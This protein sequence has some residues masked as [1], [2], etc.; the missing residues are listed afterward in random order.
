M[1]PEMRIYKVGDLPFSVELEEPWTFMH[2]TDAVL[3]RINGCAGGMPVP[4]LPTRAGDQV[5]ART[6]VTKKEE[7]PADY[8]PTTLDFSQ[9]E[10]FH[11]ETIS[12]EDTAFHMT[13]RSSGFESFSNLPTDPSVRLI[14]KITDDL[15][16]FDIY[17]KEK[18]NIFLFKYETEEVF[19]VL[20]IHNSGKAADFY[21]RA[22]TKPYNVMFHLNMALMIQY[23]YSSAGSSALLIHSS[24][25]EHDGMANMFLGESGTGKSTHSR[26]WLEHISGTSL[27]NDDN[28]VLKMVDGTPYVYG[29]PWSG[30]TPCYINKKLPVRTLVSLKQAPYNKASRL[31]GVDAFVSILTSAS[32]IRWDDRIDE[33]ITDTASSIAD[34]T[35][36]WRLECLPDEDA[37]LTCMNAIENLKS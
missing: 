9:Y 25:I 7:L 36:C 16:H 33:D 32:A 26:L 15:P 11:S 22:Q 27:L 30:K 28:P 35:P 31:S 24:V 19:A 18:D 2:Y 6:Y 13:V 21:I 20:V 8:S 1:K 3:K 4:S 14:R 23:T 12:E 10:P 34:V 29:T 37:A 17:E 5:P